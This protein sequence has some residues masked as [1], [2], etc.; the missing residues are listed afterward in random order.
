MSDMEERIRQAIIAW[1][2]GAYDADRRF[3]G[4]PDYRDPEDVAELVAAI[5]ALIAP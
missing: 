5:R 1:L 4:N 3:P 2:G